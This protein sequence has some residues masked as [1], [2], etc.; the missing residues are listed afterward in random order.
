MKK[1]SKCNPEKIGH[2]AFIIGILAAVKF[3]NVEKTPNGNSFL[4]QNPVY[5]FGA[6]RIDFSTL[7]AWGQSGKIQLTGQEVKLLKLFIAH[8]GMPIS[9][10]RLLEIGWGYPRGM[11][12]RTVDNFMVRFRKYFEPDPKK[13]V[14]F[15]SLRS[16][17]YVFDHESD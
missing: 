8:R 2:Y 15:K 17:G 9:R 11:K 13:P 3:H 14:F 12:T 4:S 5:T 16:V 7:T 6:N 1:K 10:G